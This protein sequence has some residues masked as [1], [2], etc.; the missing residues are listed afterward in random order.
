MSKNTVLA[1][2]YLFIKLPCS[3]LIVNFINHRLV[4]DFLIHLYPNQIN[5]VVTIFTSYVSYIY[6][7]LYL[8]AQQ[9]NY[10]IN[11]LTKFPHF[12][13]GANT[14][15]VM[16]AG[17]IV[18]YICIDIVLPLSQKEKKDKETLLPWSVLQVW[19]FANKLTNP[20]FVHARIVLVRNVTPPDIFYISAFIKQN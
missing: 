17:S 5:T 15:T 12:P 6:E 8:W 14:S 4:F 1:D 18:Y 20:Y 16:M 7:L 11:L 10:T 2:F 13:N 9:Y 3:Y 19:I